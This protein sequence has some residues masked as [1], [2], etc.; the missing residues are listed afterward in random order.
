MSET[1]AIYKHQAIY[2]EKQKN[3]GNVRVSVWVPE[4]KKEEIILLAADLRARART[5]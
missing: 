5:K 4:T 1:P 3:T 2:T